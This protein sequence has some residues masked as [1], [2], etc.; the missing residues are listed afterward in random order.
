MEEVM[1]V[2]QTVAGYLDACDAEFDVLHHART[3][4]SAETARVAGIP[5]AALAKAVMLEGPDQLLLAVVPASSRVDCGQLAKVLR[6]RKPQLAPESELPYVFRDC[7]QGAVPAT[8]HAF[9]LPTIVDDALLASADV[10]FEAGDHEHLIHMKGAE[11]ARIMIGQPHG[12]I[13]T[14]PNTPSLTSRASRSPS[15]P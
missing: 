8:G 14:K 13:S 9:G 1:Y 7:A 12:R 10:Y 3:S 15:S 4:C 11:F 6:D 2:S 5:E